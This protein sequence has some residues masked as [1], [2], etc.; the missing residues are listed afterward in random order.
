MKKSNEIKLN[1]CGKHRQYWV[2]NCPDC[3]AD[4][5]E[6]DTKIEFGDFLVDHYLEMK[7]RE[8]PDALSLFAI[9]LNYEMR[10][11]VKGLKERCLSK[12]TLEETR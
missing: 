10:F 7:R 3:M 5:V 12:P 1:W 9:I 2:I 8:N 6:T 11:K 4:T